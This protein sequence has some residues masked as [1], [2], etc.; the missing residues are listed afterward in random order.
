MIFICLCYFFLVLFRFANGEFEENLYEHRIH[1]VVTHQ[2]TQRAESVIEYLNV[3]GA[4]IL[5]NEKSP[6]VQSVSRSPAICN[7]NI[8][9]SASDGIN[10]ISPLEK[11]QLLFNK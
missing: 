10:L 1:D 4:G 6:A 11:I 3:T 5:H 9:H 2:T 7:I 8:T